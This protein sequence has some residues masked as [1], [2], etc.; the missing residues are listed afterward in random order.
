MLDKPRGRQPMHVANHIK[1]K[2]KNFSAHA[3]SRLEAASARA[4]EKSFENDEEEQPLHRITYPR[5]PSVAPDTE[6][7]LSPGG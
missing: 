1:K 5:A 2:Q 7:R 6:C 3:A 4:E